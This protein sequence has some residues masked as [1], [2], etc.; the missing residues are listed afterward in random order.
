MRECAYLITP[1]EQDAIYSSQVDSSNANR[2]KRSEG[3]PVDSVISAMN[4]APWRY[5]RADIDNNGYTDLVID[6][7]IVV[8]VMDMGSVFEA[9]TFSISLNWDSYGFKSFALL[10]DG[11]FAL[12]LRHDHNSCMSVRHSNLPGYV[13]Y[14]TDTVSNKKN[15]STGIKVDTLYK[16]TE[17]VVIAEEIMPDTDTAKM[18][19]TPYADTVDMKLYN[20]TDTIVY[21][22]CGFTSYHPDAK[23]QKISKI[24]YNYFLNG[25]VIGSDRYVCME[26]G[27]NGI[28]SLQYLG[29]SAVFSAILDSV[30]LSQLFDFISYIDIKSKKDIYR[31]EIDHSTGGA[32]AVSFNDGTQK[33]IYIWSHRPPMDLGYLSE[34][35]S[36]IA[37]SLKW[38][39]AAKRSDFECPCKSPSFSAYDE[40]ESFSN[41][42]EC[43]CY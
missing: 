11:T 6:A 32:F 43:K 39:P 13:T 3:Y 10:P 30:R 15:N 7:G 22:L 5:Y 1:D 12:L 18:V 37:M 27:S 16:I 25:G 8:V 42:K 35:L 24:N 19:K 26:I 31:C 28:C 36:N 21:K 9:H 34:A 14:I 29:D 33:S 40:N 20:M 38:K 17:G 23:H 2:K 41:Y 4:R